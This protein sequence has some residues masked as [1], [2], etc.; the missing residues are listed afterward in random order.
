M[1]HQKLTQILYCLERRNQRKYFKDIK[2]LPS[3]E[4]KH[5]HNLLYKPLVCEFTIRKLKSTRRKLVPTRKTWR[6]HEDRDTIKR[7]INKHRASSQK[8][9]SV[10]GNWNVLKEGL[11]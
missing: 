5:N 8:D 6:L 7:Y 2:F 1:V 3:E 4:R 9:G 11:L 10:E